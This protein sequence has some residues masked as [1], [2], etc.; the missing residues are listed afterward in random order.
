M[1]RILTIALVLLTLT[2][3]FNLQAKQV[4]VDFLKGVNGEEMIKGF[5]LSYRTTHTLYKDVV[6]FG[7]LSVY[8]ELGWSYWKYDQQAADETEIGIAISPVFTKAFATID[9]RP[10]SWE[11]GIGMSLLSNKEFAGKNIGS[12][13]QFEDRLGLSYPL[14]DRQT[15]TISIRY[16][17]YSNGGV[18]RH[19]P[20]LD[21]ANLSFAY[22]F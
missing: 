19:N 9:G 14:D 12:Y 21:F 16:M 7:D 10:L 6:I 11:F 18:S 1:D 3:P 2:V 13:Y 15:M 8:F 5:R 20:G 22:K 4:A 17:H